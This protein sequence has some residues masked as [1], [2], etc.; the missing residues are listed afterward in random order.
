MSIT[1]ITEGIRL[2]WLGHST[3]QAIS[4]ANKV[5]LIDPWVEG[6]P[7]FPESFKEF[8]K[9]DLILVTHGHFDHIGDAPRLAKEHDCTVVSNFETSLWLQSKGIAEDKAIGMNKGGTFTWEGID[10]TMV[11]AEH[12][13]GILDEGKIIYGG[14]PCGFVIRFENGFRIYHAGDTTVFGDMKI[15]GNLYHP[16]IAILPIGGH[17][18]MGPR[19]AALAC[20]L[21]G[22]RQVIPCHYGTFPVLTGT[23]GQ[24]RD[25]TRDITDF[26]VIEA[27]IGET[28]T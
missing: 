17:Y 11:P 28:I 9:I 16:D 25:L 2:T 23:P 7:A 18:L 20:R 26:E 3:F 22:V 5:I 24:L 15:I 14:D 13:G 12:S 1:N 4:S 27:K 19:E 10:C 8:P 21:L 6:N